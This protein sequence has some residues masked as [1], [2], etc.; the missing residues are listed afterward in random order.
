MRYCYRWHT[1]SL[2]SL[3]Q[4][5]TFL[6]C[7]LSMSPFLQLPEIQDHPRLQGPHHKKISDFYAPAQVVAKV[8]API[9]LENLD[10]TPSPPFSTHL[11]S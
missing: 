7:S 5:P 1:A 3:S 4:H 9:T 2:S 10:R 11:L 6:S 8:R